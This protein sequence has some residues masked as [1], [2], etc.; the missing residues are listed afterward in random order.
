MFFLIKTKWT[1]KEGKFS[2][3]IEK[4]L[5]RF[6]TYWIS[7]DILSM[8][9]ES[10][11][12]GESIWITITSYERRTILQSNPARFFPQRFYR[13]LLYL[14][15]ILLVIGGLIGIFLLYNI[16]VTISPTPAFSSIDKSTTT[17]P[18]TPIASMIEIWNLLVGRDWKT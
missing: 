14:L 18:T 7:V 10:V 13:F 4:N 2:R 6:S 12:T 5:F 16:R 17:T 15:L 8:E 3:T 11:A 1:F 9:L